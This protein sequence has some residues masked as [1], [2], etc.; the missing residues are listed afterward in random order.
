[1]ILKLYHIE[2]NNV[3]PRFLQQKCGESL[4][5]SPS[6][7]FWRI[8]SSVTSWNPENIDFGFVF[9]VSWHKIHPKSR[10]RPVLQF[11]TAVL[12][13][14]TAVLRFRTA[15]LLFRTGLG[16]DFGWILCQLTTQNRAKI[17][18]KSHFGFVLGGKWAQNPPKI[19]AKTGSTI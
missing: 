4:Q 1:M 7:G 12:R 18:A 11:R 8:L 15:V 13:F 9:G 2:S 17:V 16:L 10:P 3:F 14:R 19:E 5:L 6:F